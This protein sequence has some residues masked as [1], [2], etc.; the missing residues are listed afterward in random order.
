[1]PRIVF[2]N[3]GK[4]SE[5]VAGRTV[6]DVAKELRVSISHVCDGE[7]TCGT[8]RILCV[9]NPENL[10]PIEPNELAYD[11]GKDVRLSC[12]ARVRGDVGVRV[13]DVP[14]ALNLEKKP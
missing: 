5:V 11:M 7:G 12:H 10:S 3:E 13:I 1:M 6:L 2:L 4:R 9:V 14:R 8:C